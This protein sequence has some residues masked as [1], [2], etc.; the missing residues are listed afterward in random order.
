[1]GLQFYSPRLPRRLIRLILSLSISGAREARARPSRGSGGGA[2]CLNACAVCLG[3][4]SWAHVALPLHL[5]HVWSEKKP[6]QGAVDLQAG[7]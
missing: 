3:S 4:L 7:R 5:V 2:C 1:M 6:P